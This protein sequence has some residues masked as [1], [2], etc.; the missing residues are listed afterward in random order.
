MGD[1]RRLKKQF[2]K[3]AHPTEGQ[4]SLKNWNMLVDSDYVI[5]KNFGIQSQL[6][7]FRKLARKAKNFAAEQQTVY[8]TN[9]F[10][11]K[12]IRIN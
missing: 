5:R 2:D 1:I 11:F 6:G 8:P 3:P 4:E 7:H 9:R 12:Q 10:S